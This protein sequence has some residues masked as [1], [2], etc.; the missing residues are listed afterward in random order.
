MKLRIYILS[1]CALFSVVSFAQKSDSSHVDPLYPF[2]ERGDQDRGYYGVDNRQ[3]VTEL[4]GYEELVSATIVMVPKSQ[5]QGNK[6]YTYSLQEKLRNRF[7]INNFDPNVKFLDQPTCANCTG[8]LIS[9]DIVATAG[10]CL[11]LENACEDYVWV[12]DYTNQLTHVDNQ[13][14]VIVDPDNIYTC[15]EILAWD[16][17]NNNLADYGFLRLNKKTNREP[18]RFRTGGAVQDYQDVYMIGSPSGLPLKLADNAYVVDNASGQYFST[19]L[20]AF[21]GNSGGPVF[22]NAGWIEG[23]LVRGDIVTSQGN[24]TSGDYVYDANCNCIKT[25]NFTS[26][27]GRNGAQ[28]QRIEWSNYDILKLAIYENLSYA[29]NTNNLT[30]LNKW[31]VYSWILDNEI[32]GRLGR[33]EFDAAKLNNLDALKML[34]GKVKDVNNVDGEG[35]NLLHYAISNNNAEMLQYLLDMGVNPNRASLNNINPLYQAVSQ[36]NTQLTKLLIERTDNSKINELVNGNTLLH[37][38]ASYGNIEMAKLILD[39]G[40]DINTKNSKGY[41]AIKVAKKAKQKS[42]KKFLKKEK[43]RRK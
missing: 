38:A 18:Y 33:L 22:D 20:D 17:N 5:V 16:L 14:Y 39:A 4:K 26:T 34:M 6:I 28:V 29:I 36:N 3:D 19:S 21:P 40:G 35:K 10:H 42:M 31:L 43:K 7:G 24:R 11:A 12:L 27:F 13:D 30:R 37:L 1:I 25:L 32:S 15:D 41:S 23:I 2:G 8:F 9:P